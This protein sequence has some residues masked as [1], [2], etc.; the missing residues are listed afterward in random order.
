MSNRGLGQMGRCTI[1]MM[2]WRHTLTSLF[3]PQASLAE[4]HLHLL[5]EISMKELLLLVLVAL[6]ALGK[7]R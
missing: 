4:E 2:D 3:T 7:R 1:A 5:T 6:L